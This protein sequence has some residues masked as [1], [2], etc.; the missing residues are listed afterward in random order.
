M[1]GNWLKLVPLQKMQALNLTYHVDDHQVWLGS[2]N[3]IYS[4]H[5]CYKLLLKK[6]I[7]RL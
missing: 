2:G 1:I 3:G 4:V 5:S 6:K 7:R